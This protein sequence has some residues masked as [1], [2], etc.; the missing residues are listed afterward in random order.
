MPEQKY[1]RFAGSVFR[2]SKDE[3]SNARKG[4]S[5]KWKQL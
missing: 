1:M 2:A 4:A 5:A 3:G